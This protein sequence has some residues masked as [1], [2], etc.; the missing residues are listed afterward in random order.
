MGRRS[1]LTAAQWDA[2]A[3][4]I[5]AGESKRAVAREFALSES[6]LRESLAR[7]RGTETAAHSL[8]GNRPDPPPPAHAA[9]SR[10]VCEAP[11]AD[12]DAPGQPSDLIASVRDLVAWARAAATAAA[13]SHRQVWLSA[14]RGS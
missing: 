9:P 11:A 8:G 2:V 7:R 10:A 13:T 1:K 4:R 5:A 12:V 3:Q 6:A 14:E